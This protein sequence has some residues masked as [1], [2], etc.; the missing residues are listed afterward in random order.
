MS[1]ILQFLI[2]GLKLWQLV[3]VPSLFLVSYGIFSDISSWKLG[4]IICVMIVELY[5]LCRYIGAGSRA[6]SGAS[7]TGISSVSGQADSEKMNVETEEPEVQY[8]LLAN[9]RGALMNMVEDVNGADEEDQDTKEC[10]SLFKD[11]KFFLCREVS[12][13]HHLCSTNTEYFMV[14]AFP[15]ILQNCIFLTFYIKKFPFI[16]MKKY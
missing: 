9:E 7:Q 10:K 3:P 5:A 4:D 6:L 13:F 8:Q 16:C 15:M 12:I 2:P 14:C 1:S 11:L